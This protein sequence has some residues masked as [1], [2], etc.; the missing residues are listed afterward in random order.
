MLHFIFLQS[1]LPRAVYTDKSQVSEDLL[2]HVI[3][4]GNVTDS[5]QIYKLLEGDVK[6]ETKLA[7]FEM[8]CF[9]NST[10]PIDDELI[11]ERWFSISNRSAWVSTWK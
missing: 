11:E 7:L 3:K 9:Y 4:F 6:V 8:L 10:P 1:F 5:L 2:V